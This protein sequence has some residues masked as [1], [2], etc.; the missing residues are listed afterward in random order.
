MA[1]RNIGREAVDGIREIKRFKTG[2]AE[3]RTRELRQPAPAQEIRAQLQLSQSAFAKLMG[4]SVR[5]V[6]DWEQGRREPRGAAR[7]LLHIAQQRPEVFDTIYNQGV[8]GNTLLSF[9]GTISPKD[10]S[11]M[12]NA[13]EQECEKVDADE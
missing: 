11:L 7:T 9:A 2:E 10:L 12:E 3:L 13:I 8:P 5:T 4:V 6:Q 1:E